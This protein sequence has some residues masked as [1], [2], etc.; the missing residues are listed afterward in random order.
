MAAVAL[1]QGYHFANC[2]PGREMP[3]SNGKSTHSL[4]VPAGVELCQHPRKSKTFPGRRNCKVRGKVQ[5]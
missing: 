1:D 2:L 4:S 3:N 5:I